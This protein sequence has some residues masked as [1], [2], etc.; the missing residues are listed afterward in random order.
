MYQELLQE[1]GLSLN[2][3]RTYEAML[4][5]GKSS[6]QTI[7]LRSGVHRR[8]VYDALAKLQEKGLAFESF[9]HGEKHFQATNPHHLLNILSERQERLQ[10]AMKSMHERYAAIQTHEEAYVYKGI[11]GFKN[12]FQDILDTGETVHFIGAKGFWLDPRLSVAL[13]RF[14]RERKKRGIAFRHL[15]DAD[16]KRK[17]PQI[18]R[19]VGAGYRFMPEQY[20]SSTAIDIF[21]PYVVT[22]VGVRPG[23][24]PE[25]PVMFVMK[26][27]RLAD[28]YRNFFEFMWDSCT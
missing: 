10:A 12:Y 20:S 8:N 17:A 24:L 21:G 18:L 1:L 27:Q 9:D 15:F 23:E 5:I 7:S 22:F 26:S 3:S 16:V 28:G 4:S 2:E 19:K 13:A 11:E 25:Q 6:V 14:D